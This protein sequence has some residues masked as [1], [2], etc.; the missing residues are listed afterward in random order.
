MRKHIHRIARHVH[1]HLHRLG[2]KRSGYAVFT[3]GLVVVALLAYSVL[4]TRSSTP[5]GAP[6]IA[7]VPQQVG[8]GEGV[9]ACASAASG[10]SCSGTSVS[11]AFDYNQDLYQYNT[12]DGSGGLTPGECG[13]TSKSN[14]G[15]VYTFMPPLYL[16]VV[17]SSGAA[18]WSGSTSSCSGSVVAT[19]VGVAGNQ[20]RFETYTTNST[21]Y[22]GGWYGYHAGVVSYESVPFTA[23]NCA[24][25]V[26]GGWSAW[27]ACS[28]S[29]GGGTQTRNCTN[30]APSGGGAA[31]SGSSSQSCN[32][33]ACGP[34]APSPSI[35]ASCQDYGQEVAL[36]WGAVPNA[37]TYYLRIWT[38]NGVCPSGWQLYSDG[39]TCTYNDAG[40]GTGNVNTSFL[41]SPFPMLA[42]TNYS[43]WVHPG[44]P[45]YWSNPPTATFACTT[46]ADVSSVSASCNSA[47]N[48][49]TFSWP[50]VS[51]AN[52]YQIQYYSANHTCSSG[53]TLWTNGTTCYLDIPSSVAPGTTVSATASVTPGQASSAWVNAGNT[54]TGWANWS[55]QPSTN[56]TCVAP[57]LV[58]TSQ[59]IPGSATPG[60]ATPLSGVV[61][62]QGTAGTGTSFTDVFEINPGVIPSTFSGIA[63]L[64][65]ISD[66]PLAIGATHTDSVSYAFPS[67]GI[68]YVRLCADTG[69]SGTG[70]IAESNETNN[71]G[72]WT[73]VTA[74]AITFAGNGCILA[75]DAA[76]ATGY[77]CNIHAWWKVPSLPAGDSVDLSIS[78]P[79]ALTVRIPSLPRNSTLLKEAGRSLASVISGLSATAYP[80]LSTAYAYQ[81]TQAGKYTMQLQQHSNGA[82]L[83]TAIGLVACPPGSTIQTDTSGNETC[84]VPGKPVGG[85][86]GAIPTITFYANPATINSGQSTA[87]YWS[88]TNST[89]CNP[90]TG[91]SGFSTGGATQSPA[92]G[93]S[94][95]VLTTDTNYDITCTGSGGSATKA[96]T[97][98]VLPPGVTISASPD[99]VPQGGQTT[100]SWNATNVKSCSIARNGAPW[101]PSGPKANLTADKSGNVSGSAPDT[102]NTT[103]SYVIT[104]QD[105]TAASTVSATGVVNVAS[106]YGNF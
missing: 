77:S 25:V 93:V 52:V 27:S 46:P 48:Q 60:A 29:C 62:N 86:G 23:P 58:V 87:L 12:Y 61:K 95:G 105:A 11:M 57:D 82:P 39:H 24:P 84:V 88:S 40:G 75:P 63:T 45:P 106:G 70:S 38:P 13:I 53:W 97:V 31:C 76:S 104:C 3:A 102:I 17:D 79:A 28:A 14:P 55:A 99:R 32:T 42:N 51:G 59:A 6:T 34:T 90:T 44:N 81:V 22:V 54:S 43:A 41:T 5:S 83:G 100:V 103:T 91:T 96:T 7:L 21:Y 69:L 9:P 8:L 68:Y 101:T 72:A 33:Q 98:T 85:T 73:S 78:N 35:S 19:F 15:V 66:G 65:A 47:G 56:F 2:A 26:N 16:R 36:N 64:R 18:V 50:A 10:P 37:T 49:A 89:A 20:Y 1:R 67:A 80:S 94:T 30:P 71:C 74:A 4:L 92:A